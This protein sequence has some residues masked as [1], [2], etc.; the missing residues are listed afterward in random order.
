MYKPTKE[1]QEKYNETARLK[2][3]NDPKY[4]EKVLESERKWKNKNRDKLRLDSQLR[5]KIHKD[6]ISAKRKKY[7]KEHKEEIHMN[8]KKYYEREKEKYKNDLEYREKRLRL[9]RERQR[10]NSEDRNVRRR[11]TYLAKKDKI[12]AQRREYREEHGE[13]IRAKQNE[14]HEKHKIKTNSN[15]RD[16]YKN[17]EEYREYTKFKVQEFRAKEEN[18]NPIEYKKKLEQYKEAKNI[19]VNN[20]KNRLRMY[21]GG[22]CEEC[23]CDDLSKLHFHHIDPIIKEFKVFEKALV[24]YMSP[25]IIEEAKKCQ[26]LCIDCHA[27]HHSGENNIATKLNEKQ[28]EEIFFTNYTGNKEKE[29]ELAKEYG[30]SKTTIFN[31]QHLR[32]MSPFR[33]AVIMD[34]ISRNMITPFSA[35]SEDC[36]TIEFEGE[37]HYFKKF[38]KE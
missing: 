32:E 23:G 3:K 15:R 9:N 10:R 18:E 25:E 36:F 26:L 12:N 8:A 34:A 28:I 11:E 17:D 1:Q 37:N 31:I 30:V 21:F 20:A 13:E 27:R 19:A 5:Y 24:D 22:K 14:Y 38:I 4:R 2:R 29:I 35:D 33:L 6:T 16:R 7:R